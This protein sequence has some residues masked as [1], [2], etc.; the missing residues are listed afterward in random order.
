M[1]RLREDVLELLGKQFAVDFAVGVA[2][3]AA[4]PDLDPARQHESGKMKLAG[5]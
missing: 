5:C 4:F 2:R 3:Q 1:R